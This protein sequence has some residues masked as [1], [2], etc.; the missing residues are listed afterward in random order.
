MYSTQFYSK[1]A[2]VRDSNPEQK[3]SE[4]CL[5]PA[6]GVLHRSA[7]NAH[8][9]VAHGVRH[10]VVLEHPKNRH[11]P[12]ESRIGGEGNRPRDHVLVQGRVGDES[13]GHHRERYVGPHRT[14]GSDPPRRDNRLADEAPMVEE[15]G[16]SGV[17]A[18][19]RTVRVGG[20]YIEV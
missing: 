13:V 16:V 19:A 18:E 14:L 5:I 3:V 4:F 6:I 12:G 8:G 11:R 9:D 1:E 7:L 2:L 10:H 20:R 15:L 17:V